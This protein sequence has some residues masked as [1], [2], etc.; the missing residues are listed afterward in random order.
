[1]KE[2]PEKIALVG[3]GRDTQKRRDPET[4]SHQAH[5]SQGL[6][7]DLVPVGFADFTRGQD[8]EISGG[9]Y[10]VGQLKAEELIC[11]LGEIY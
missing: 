9:R 5:Q 8:P 1:L 11:V 6:A 2:S 4:G 10:Q 3:A 7:A